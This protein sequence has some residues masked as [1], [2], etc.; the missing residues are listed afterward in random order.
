MHLVVS[1]ILLHHISHTC[2][3]CV[4]WC[5]LLRA[6]ASFDGIDFDSVKQELISSHVTIANVDVSDLSDSCTDLIAGRS[7]LS[8]RDALALARHR[9][10]QAVLTLH[11]N[12]DSDHAR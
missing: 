2:I 9:L 10:L 7:W 8:A 11:V 1:L 3:I 6:L 4:C 12:D 5:L